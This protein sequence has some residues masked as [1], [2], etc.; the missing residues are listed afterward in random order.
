M[1]ALESLNETQLIQIARNLKKGM[2]IVIDMPEERRNR[3]KD[4]KNCP[5][6]ASFQMN[7]G[8]LQSVE[9][10]ARNKGFDPTLPKWGADLIGQIAEIQVELMMEK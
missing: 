7:L 1:N 10:A 2:M 4:E 3:A 6:F 8:I 5:P 9:R